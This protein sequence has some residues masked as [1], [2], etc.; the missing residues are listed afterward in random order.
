MANA[1]DQQL[2]RD[3]LLASRGKEESDQILPRAS[4]MSSDALWT[5]FAC[6]IAMNLTLHSS[7][8]KAWPFLCCY[9]SLQTVYSVHG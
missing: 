6:H 4:A 3:S 1:T 2:R 8:P 9:M 7:T 5:V